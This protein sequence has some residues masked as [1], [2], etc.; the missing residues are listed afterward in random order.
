MDK[1]T[2]ALALVLC[3]I[4]IYIERSLPWI[5]FGKKQMPALM[6]RLSELLPAALMAI[7]V[8]YSLKALTTSDMHTSVSLI[9]ASVFTVIIHLWKKNQILSVIVG[10]AV[11]MLFLNLF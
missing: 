10:T 1:S 4:I 7:L 9:I 11:Y 8:V 5:L 3:A 6:K 2:A